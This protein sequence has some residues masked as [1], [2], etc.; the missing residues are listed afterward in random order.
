MDVTTS[1]D[2]QFGCIST[3]SSTRR[4][5]ADIGD[6][7]NHPVKQLQNILSLAYA[8]KCVHFFFP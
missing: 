7:F 8:I 6:E 4:I 1:I 3:A 5:K 2:P